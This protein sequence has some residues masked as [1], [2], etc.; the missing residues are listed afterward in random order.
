[1]ALQVPIQQQI[2]T[3]D[4]I[5]E[6][7]EILKKISKAYQETMVALETTSKISRRSREIMEVSEIILILT[8]I[9]IPTKIH[10]AV[11]EMAQKATDKLLLLIT[12][13][14]KETVLDDKYSK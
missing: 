12:K 3:Q 10:L 2:Q 5:A 6:A 9:R 14:Q 11:L 1:M 4:K 8:K 7:S 13:V